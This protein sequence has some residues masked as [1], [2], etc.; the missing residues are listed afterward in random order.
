M[1]DRRHNRVKRRPRRTSEE[2]REWRMTFALAGWRADYSCSSRSNW[3]CV[4]FELSACREREP[5]QR[6]TLFD[7]IR[8]HSSSNG[9]PISRFLS[10]PLPSRTMLHSRQWPGNYS[11]SSMELVSVVCSTGYEHTSLERSSE[12]FALLVIVSCPRVVSRCVR[13][14]RSGGPLGGLAGQ[15]LPQGRRPEHIRSAGKCRYPG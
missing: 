6:K 9:E 10:L 2:D 12:Q 14:S 15:R 4:I 1:T 5:W 8:A 13:D 11:F 7:R 3:S